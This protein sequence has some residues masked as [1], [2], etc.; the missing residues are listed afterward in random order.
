[1]FS[2]G[3][4]EREPKDESAEERLRRRAYERGCQRLKKRIEGQTANQRASFVLIHV[5]H[6]YYTLIHVLY[7]YYTLMIF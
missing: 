6:T 1:M 4:D 2:Q 3:K 5:L 7:T